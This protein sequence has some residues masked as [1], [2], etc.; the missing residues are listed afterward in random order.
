[1]KTINIFSTPITIKNDFISFN[2]SE[3]DIVQSFEYEEKAHKNY[4][5][6]DY[7]VLDKL[8]HVNKKIKHYLID[9]GRDV[10][11]L[12][13]KNELYITNSWCVKTEKGGFHPA[14]SH[15]NSLLSGVFYINIGNGNQHIIFEHEN[16]V[17]KD[18]KFLLDYDR[19]THYN[20]NKFA[21]ALKNNDLILFPSW[22][23]HEVLENKTDLTRLV[24]GFNVFIKGEMGNNNYPTKLII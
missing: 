24:L 10:L 17:F 23:K 8:E 15:P 3:L 19:D 20:T 21:V 12:K 4:F 22:L 14:H 18:Y 5:T 13:S 9:Y 11:G 16:Q 7:N 2:R 1:M 6:K